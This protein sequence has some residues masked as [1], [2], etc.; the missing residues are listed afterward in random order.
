MFRLHAFVWN[1]PP[2]GGSRHD[3]HEIIRAV[4]TRLAGN[5]NDTLIGNGLGNILDGRGGNDVIRGNNGED[6]IRGKVG[7]DYLYG[8]SH[9]DWFDFD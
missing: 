8:G 5:G 7:K 4:R 3:G 9:R 6:L 2:V 1:A